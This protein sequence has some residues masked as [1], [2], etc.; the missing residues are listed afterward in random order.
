L[1][2]VKPLEGDIGTSKF[3]PLVTVAEPFALPLEINRTAFAR[4]S[5]SLWSIMREL[6][7]GELGL[8]RAA[9]SEAPPDR[10]GQLISESDLMWRRGCGRAAM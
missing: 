7:P 2:R 9:A 6:D 5:Y 1:C 4:T 3:K 8:V 10:A